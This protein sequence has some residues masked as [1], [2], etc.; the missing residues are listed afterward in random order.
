MPD[1]PIRDVF[2]PLG[3]IVLVLFAA[4]VVLFALL[5]V[6]RENWVFFR[7]RRDRIRA[8]LAPVVERLVSAIDPDRTTEELRPLIASMDRQERPVAAWLLRDLTRDADPRTIERVR[9]ILDE[10]GAIELAERSTRRWMPWRRALACEMLG[11]IGAERSVPV[12]L[13]RLDDNRG[14]VRMAAARALGAIGAPGAAGA[15]TSVFL[16]RT[17]VP[18]G[19]AYDALRALGPAGAP[20]FHR[21][22]LSDDPTVRLASCFGVAWQAREHGDTSAVTKLTRVLETDE[23]VRVRTAATMALGLVGGTT[24]PRALVDALRDPQIRVRREAVA[25]LGGFDE[26]DV[27]DE[28]AELTGDPDREVALR[29][30]EALVAF[31]KRPRAGAAASDALATA[32]A[33]SVDYARTTSELAA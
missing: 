13:E 22:I 20:A 12:L 1:F 3:W 2:A 25:A 19:V 7:R 9:E 10:T 32:S 16:S 26:P 24:P 5:V 33:W 28:L 8:R 31:S 4:N 23:N 30:A 6:L 11:A 17:A 14:E 27:V 21:G 15:L 29:A 18:T